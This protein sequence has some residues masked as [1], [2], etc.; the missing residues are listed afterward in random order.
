MEEYETLKHENG[1]NSLHGSESLDV[2]SQNV[3]ESAFTDPE[4]ESAELPKPTDPFKND[5]TC[6]LGQIVDPFEGPAVTSGF[7]VTS[8]GFATDDSQKVSMGFGDDGFGD[9]FGAEEV[10]NNSCSS[11]PVPA[12]SSG[13]DDQFGF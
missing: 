11:Q 8:D 3:I 5:A 10:S 13:F 4:L 9:A 2:N 7:E 12:T 1:I 6:D